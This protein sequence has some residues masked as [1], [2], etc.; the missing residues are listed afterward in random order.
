MW[1]NARNGR[2]LHEMMWDMVVTDEMKWI[3]CDAMKAQKLDLKN[4]IIGCH[5]IG[6]HSGPMEDNVSIGGVSV[7]S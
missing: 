6:G 5:F 2:F 3:S 1:A 7:V 4:A